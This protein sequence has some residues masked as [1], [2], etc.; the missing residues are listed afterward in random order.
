MEK[1]RGASVAGSS[2]LGRERTAV[3]VDV[4]PERRSPRYH[5]TCLP[6]ELKLREKK[7]GFIENT[8]MRHRWG[9]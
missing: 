9:G 8:A 1:M 5:E 4:C 2:F 3:D 6:H 7:V